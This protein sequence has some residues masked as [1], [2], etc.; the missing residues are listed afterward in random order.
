MHGR[1]STPRYGLRVPIDQATVTSRLATLEQW[2]AVF[3][4]LGGSIAHGPPELNP[5]EF[6]LYWDPDAEWLPITGGSVEGRSYRGLEGQHAYWQDVADTWEEI[7]AM[8]L[9][10][11]VSKAGAVSVLKLG[12]RGRASG[13][14]IQT[15]TG[16]CWEFRGHRIVRGRAYRDPA[17]AFAAAG[18]APR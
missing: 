3:N 12:A 16:V 17:E 18:I 11:E 2:T 8:T 1:G 6:E 7:Q 15:V 9:E 5:A 13:L 4:R 14:E 10:V